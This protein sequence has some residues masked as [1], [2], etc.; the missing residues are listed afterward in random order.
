MDDK[1]KTDD[2]KQNKSSDNT[3]KDITETVEVFEAPQSFEAKFAEDF[4][5]LSPEWQRFLCF[6]E[7]QFNQAMNACMA[8]LQSY[9]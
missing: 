6:H 1:P 5:N 7:E 3:E 4:K 9:G 2:T 8:K